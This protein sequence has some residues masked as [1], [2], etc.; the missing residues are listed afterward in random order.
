MGSRSGCG[1]QTSNLSQKENY[2]KGIN[3]KKEEIRADEPEE[4]TSGSFKRKSKWTQLYVGRH[5]RE[6]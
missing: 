5:Y 3:A 2:P 4:L 6:A 1:S